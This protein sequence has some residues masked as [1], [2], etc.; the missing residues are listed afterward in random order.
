VRCGYIRYDNGTFVGERVQVEARDGKWCDDVAA[1][2]LDLVD[3]MLLTDVSFA[4]EPRLPST[5]ERRLAVSFST[6][7]SG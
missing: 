5:A 3:R 2:E 6:F 1:P 7:S 4:V